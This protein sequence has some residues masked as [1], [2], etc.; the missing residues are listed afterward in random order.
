MTRLE[1]VKEELLE[2]V[3]R[4]ANMNIEDGYLQRPTIFADL[5][6]LIQGLALCMKKADAIKKCGNRF[7]LGALLEKWDQ[8]S[9]S[10]IFNLLKGIK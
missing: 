7:E 9:R 4:E 5:A 8:K 1:E 2:E 3:V 10:E 6:G